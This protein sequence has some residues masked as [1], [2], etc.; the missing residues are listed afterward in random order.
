MMEWMTY[1]LPFCSLLPMNRSPTPGFL[2]RI[3]SQPESSRYF[4]TSSESMASRS[5][6]S[7]LMSQGLRVWRRFRKLHL[8]VREASF[9]PNSNRKN[10]YRGTLSASNHCSIGNRRKWYPGSSRMHT[11]MCWPPYRRSSCLWRGFGHAWGHRHWGGPCV[12]ITAWRAHVLSN[13]SSFGTNFWNAHSAAVAAAMQ[14]LIRAV[15]R[16][17]SIHSQT[18]CWP[19]ASSF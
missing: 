13:D 9:M 16:L 8:L 5:K 10:W 3:K 2:N 1:R 7:A 11:R 18:F 6:M 17:A 4:D 12:S 14:R 15:E 19:S